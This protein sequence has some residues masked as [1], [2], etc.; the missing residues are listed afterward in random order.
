M[1]RVAIIGGGGWGT[2]LSIA[3]ARMG[4]RIRLWVYEPEL[5]PAINAGRSNPLYLSDFSIPDSVVATDSLAFGLEGAEIV[6]TAVP[7]NC[8]RRLYREMLPYLRPE[9]VL[10]SATK[11]IESTSLQRMSQV[12][13][14]VISPSFRPRIAAISGPSFAREVARGDPTAIVV[15]GPDPTVNR[16]VQTEFS[17]P[18]L[19]LYTNTDIIGVELGGAV[20]NV[21]AIA[22]G[23]CAGM[24]LGCNSVAAVVTRGLAEMTRLVVACG[25]R[26]ETM[27]GLAGVGDLVLTCHGELSR[28]RRVGFQLGKGCGLAD[29]TAG[30]RT[31]AEGIPATGATL[32]LAERYGV[33]MPI[34]EQMNLLLHHRKEPREA[35]RD[36]M[37]RRLKEE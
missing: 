18:S 4:H 11:G 32:K 5:V 13:E 27:A 8:C 29:I 28:N 37:K 36:L 22:A 6:L 20:K 19:R 33:E 25:G 14:A 34:A 3:L 26:T 23:V 7:A 15:A 17:G 21:I 30:M 10:V 31:V 24:G 35:M 1:K 2:A 12:M 16:L 9:S